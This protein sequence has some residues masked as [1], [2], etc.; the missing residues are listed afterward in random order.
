MVNIPKKSALPPAR[1]GLLVILVGV[2]LYGAT[3]LIG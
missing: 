3:T 1:V 2:V